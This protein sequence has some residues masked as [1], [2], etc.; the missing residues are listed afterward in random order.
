MLLA[1]ELALLPLCIARLAHFLAP[2]P[3]TYI[4]LPQFLSPVRLMP[5]LWLISVDATYGHLGRYAS[6]ACSCTCACIR[7]L[8]CSSRRPASSSCT[9][10][11]AHS[12]ANPYPFP[13]HAV[14]P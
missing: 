6:C 13:S 10:E 11:Q 9:H 12:A 1:N 3:V 8:L 7:H 14:P 4:P 2:P 5:Y